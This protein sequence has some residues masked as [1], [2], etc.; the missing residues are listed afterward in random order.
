MCCVELDGNE[1]QQSQPTAGER[2]VATISAVSIYV[3]ITDGAART[4]STPEALNSVAVNAPPPAP[5]PPP[6]GPSHQ[7][8]S[9]SIPIPPPPPLLVRGPP[10]R[11]VG[12][13]APPIGIMPPAPPLPPRNILRASR[14]SLIPAGP[15]HPPP[16]PPLPPP[17]P[18][19]LLATPPLPPPPPVARSPTPPMVTMLMEMGF[20][21]PVA[22]IA[23]ERCENFDDT[24][25]PDENIDVLLNW[26]LGHPDA[27]ADEEIR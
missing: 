11:G 1:L 17:A 26:I 14:Q 4:S 22:R 5:P 9:S 8:R 6:I 21:R 12:P 24:R 18:I 20:D 2:S 15:P 25:P 3:F 19:I 7:Y 16:A 27:V 23:V 13:P 10:P